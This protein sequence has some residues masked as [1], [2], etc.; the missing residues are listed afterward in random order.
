MPAAPEH[1]TSSDPTPPE[2]VTAGAKHPEVQPAL[3]PEEQM[4]QY[5]ESLKESDWGHQPC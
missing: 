1:P 5:E 3:T 4:E 2:G